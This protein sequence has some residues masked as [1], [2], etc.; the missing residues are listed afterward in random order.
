MS[1]EARLIA[2]LRA[3]LTRGKGGSNT[4]TISV[5]PSCSRWRRPEPE[6]SRYLLWKQELPRDS[7]RAN[8]IYSDDVNFATA[9]RISAGLELTA[10]TLFEASITSV[11]PLVGSA[12]YFAASRCR[13]SVWG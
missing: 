7:W 9:A 10:T 1:W 8:A 4:L 2:L 11:V 3:D 13:S 5:S 12:P 6:C